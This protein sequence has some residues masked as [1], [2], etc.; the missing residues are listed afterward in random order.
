M[1]TEHTGSHI[2]W[3]VRHS[4]LRLLVLIG[5]EIVA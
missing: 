4:W 1:T 5:S 3:S 2:A